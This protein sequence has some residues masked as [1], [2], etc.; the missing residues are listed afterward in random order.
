MQSPPG[1]IVD[2]SAPPSPPQVAEIATDLRLGL[3]VT[4]GTSS[5]P[6]NPNQVV[7]KS[8]GSGGWRKTEYLFRLGRFV[9]PF[10][11]VSQYYE[12]KE[13]EDRRRKELTKE[14]NERRQRQK[15]SRWGKSSERQ[16][17]EKSNGGSDD[18]NPESEGMSTF[19]I[20]ANF[21]I[22]TSR[23][24]YF[25]QR[26]DTQMEKNAAMMGIMMKQIFKPDFPKKVRISGERILENMGP[27]AERTG[28]LMKDVWTMWV[29][30]WYNGDDDGRSGGGRR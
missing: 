2:P 8:S 21:P 24:E 12:D 5:D 7:R 19:P 28:K 18:D 26:L 22:D 30:S 14:Y 6:D 20:P 15:E 25:L 1:A 27:T 13:E 4:D 10:M 16:Q 23:I 9:P 29:S 17:E 11:V 3:A